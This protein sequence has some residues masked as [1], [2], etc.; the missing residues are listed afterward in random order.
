LRRLNASGAVYMVPASL[1]GRYVIRFT[2][3]S[4]Y[5]TDA[6]IMRDW[7]LISQTAT[8]VLRAISADLSPEPCPAAPGRVSQR[9]GLV[10]QSQAK[11]EVTR[12]G[13]GKSGVHRAGPRMP[14]DDRSVSPNGPKMSRKSRNGFKVFRSNPK[15]SKNGLNLSR[16]G[17]KVSTPGQA[18]PNWLQRVPGWSPGSVRI[19]K[20]AT[21]C[22]ICIICI[23]L[24]YLIVGH[25]IDSVK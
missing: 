20:H 12:F 1:H 14:R 18:V 21:P 6:D 19:S 22:S 4:H 2:V 5:T 7:A 15:V 17:P 8:D 11:P 13:S 23:F 25:T 3:T 10:K 16:T 24:M 9:P